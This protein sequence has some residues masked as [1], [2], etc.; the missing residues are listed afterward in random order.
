MN[1]LLTSVGRRVELVRAFRRSYER[2]RL[3]GEI[4]G[5]DVDW[6]APAMHVVDRGVIVPSCR[7]ATY[8]S[9]VLDLCQR[10]QVRMVLPLIDPEIPMLARDREE[11]VRLG[12]CCGVVDETAAGIAGDKWNTTRYFQQLDINTPRSW[13]PHDP[14]WH[15]ITFP[16]FVKPRTG[17]AGVGATRVNGPEQLAM[18]LSHLSDPIVQELIDGPEIT[19]DVICD[20]DGNALQV[21]S[22]QRIQVRGGEA[23]KS[24]TIQNEQ[25][26]E[27]CR[28]IAESLPA[29]GPITVQSIFNEHGP[30]FIEINARLGGGV[31]LAIAAGVDVPS[32]LLSL[33]AG[34]PI[35]DL[36][37]CEAEAGWY[38]TRFDESIFVKD[39]VGAK[40]ERHPL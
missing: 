13:L 34:F 3:T 37:E 16:C 39:D 5:T 22:R 11:F 18:V 25:I 36:V 10:Y 31:P 29:R 32:I 8:A 9:A 14:Q 23:I 20:F 6:L 38:M 35:E 21:V 1:I 2:L 12:I 28:R 24:V 19:S 40:L 27:S 30:V 15:D 26:A 7:D 17:S 4:I 33:A